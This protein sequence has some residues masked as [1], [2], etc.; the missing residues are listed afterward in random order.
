M[1]LVIMVLF[2]SAVFGQMYSY[3]ITTKA[4][5]TTVKVQSKT[6]MATDEMVFAVINVPVTE[7][8]YLGDYK[9]LSSAAKREVLKDTKAVKL[10]LGEGLPDVYEVQVMYS[11]FCSA[12]GGNCPSGIIGKLNNKYVL[13]LNSAGNGMRYLKSKHHGVNDIVS[14]SHVGGGANA[15]TVHEFDGLKYYA[16][17]SRSV[18]EYYQRENNKTYYLNEKEYKKYILDY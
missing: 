10:N 8:G 17:E 12:S 6:V 1:R 9:K 4:P 5:F 15:C 7:Y 2:I 13:L 16:N 11:Q 18:Y 3:A 14:Y